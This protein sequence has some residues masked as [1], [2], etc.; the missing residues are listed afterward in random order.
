MSTLR[1]VKAGFSTTI[2][3]KGRFGFRKY[4]IPVSGA[5]DLKSMMDANILVGNPK[6]NPVLECTLNGGIYQFL[7][8]ATVASTGA[9]SRIVLNG[10]VVAQYE[11]IVISKGDILELGHP[12]RGCRSYLAIKGLFDTPRV[13]GSYSTY[14]PGKFGGFLGRKLKKGDELNWMD[15]KEHLDTES[16]SKNQIPY[17]SSKIRIS[18]EQG[19]EFEFLHEEARNSLLNSK[20]QVLSQSNR[21]GIRLGGNSINPPKREIMS[22]PVKPGVIQLP[23]SGNP[24]ILMNDGQTIGGY[25]RVGVVKESELW[26]LGQ[27]KTGDQVSFT[28]T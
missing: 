7:D 26:R 9:Q 27:A 18:I 14:I 1:V 8:A 3:D 25:P 11:P 12:G 15:S 4:G 10:L 16:F 23:P 13:M 19:P 20:F 28:I 22:S 17:F 24:I 21:M 6:E 5:M 2:Q